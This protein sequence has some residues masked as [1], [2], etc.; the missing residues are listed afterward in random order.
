[1]A[2]QNG[3]DQNA[4]PVRPKYQPTDETITQPALNDLRKKIDT[5]L[6]REELQKIIDEADQTWLRNLVCCEP[7]INAIQEKLKTYIDDVGDLAKSNIE[8]KNEL[9]QLLD[10]YEEKNQGLQAL[11]QKNADMEQE[12]ASKAIS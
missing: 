10:Q 4:K 1:M 12:Y 5:E 9:K 8:L 7:E 11:Q 6:S 2:Q 3:P